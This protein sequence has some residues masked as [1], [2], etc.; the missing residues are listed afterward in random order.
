MLKK[1]ILIVVILC[2]LELFTLVFLPDMVMQVIE[3]AG[4]GIILFFLL[5]YFVYGEVRPGKMRFAF[6]V[7]LILISLVFSMIGANVFQDQSFSA[8][9]VGQRVIYYYL[10]YFLLHYLKIPVEYIRKTI[11]VFAIAYMAIYITQYVMYPTALIKSKM[12]IDRG[13]LRIFMPGAGFLVI[14]YFIWLY[15]FFKTYRIRYILLLLTAWAVFILLGTRQVIGAMLLLSIVFM[16]QSKVV[17]SRFLFFALIGI[18]IIPLYLLFQDIITA[19]FDV[20]VS[21]SQSAGSGIRVKAARFFLTDF[22]KNNWAYFTGNGAAGSTVYGL[23]VAGISER[24]GY[25]LSDI[26]LIGEYIK[27]G[28]LFVI[29]VIIIF[30][31][32]LSSRLP[33]NLMFIKYNFYGLILTLVTGAG[34]FGSVS[35]N[36]LTNCMLLY[37]IDM[38][39]N[40]NEVS[41]IKLSATAKL[42]NPYNT[43]ISWKP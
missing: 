20:T 41:D 18:A 37:M 11:V 21:Q 39:L 5:L 7:W 22:Y 13:T 27:Y 42:A 17:K 24:Y 40:E 10:V 2:S 33:E 25:Y 30:Y 31:R 28:V 23:R 16:L 6:P 9:A 15:S 43:Q 4:I 14:S 36:I 32:S 38:Y 1:F 26:G 29:A 12:F 34:A 35:I 8:T 19:M 3:M